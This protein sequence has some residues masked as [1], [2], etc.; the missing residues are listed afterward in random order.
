MA[1]ETVASCARASQAQRTD[2]SGRRLF[3]SLNRCS[4]CSRATTLPFFR[5]AL[6]SGF[7]HFVRPIDLT[8]WPDSRRIPPTVSETKIP[9]SGQIRP[10]P[11]VVVRGPK[12]D[13]GG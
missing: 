1:G 11:C 5:I 9:R 10:A 2:A 12:E 3:S 6:T 8:L 7:D 4:Q 13:H